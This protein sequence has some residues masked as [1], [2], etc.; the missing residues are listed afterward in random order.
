MGRDKATL[1]IDG[2]A[3]AD[4]VAGA[5]RAAGAAEV[6]HVGP[7]VGTL[8]ATV[9]DEPGSG[10]LGAVVAALRWAGEHNV[11]VAAC[12]LVTPAPAAFAAVIAALQ[13][14]PRASAAIPMIAGRTQPLAA[15]YAPRALQPLVEAFARGERS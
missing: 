2:V 9:E 15:A 14:S 8:G 13:S 6:V 3:M 5:L 11:L 1:E 4:R 7:A 10:P 12:D